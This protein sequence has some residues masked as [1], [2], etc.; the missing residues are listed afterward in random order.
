MASAFR[1]VPGRAR[2][3]SHGELASNRREEQELAMLCLHILHILQSCLA[4][5]NT[6]MIKDTLALPEWAGVLTDADQR[7]IT[8]LFHT[9]MIPYGE[10]QLRPDRRL[11][12]SATR[13]DEQDST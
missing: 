9:H 10:V 12:L 1:P 7:G 5:I 4:Y 11:N 8:P 3:G 13:T 2:F 6:L